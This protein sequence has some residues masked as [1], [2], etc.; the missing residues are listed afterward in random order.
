M[1][2]PTL[3]EQ[4]LNAPDKL[5]NKTFGYGGFL[6]KVFRNILAV[7]N[8]SNEQ[9]NG[10]LQRYVNAQP[11][12]EGKPTHY[13][14]GI[15]GNLAKAILQPHISWKTF[16]RGLQILRVVKFKMKI[17]LTYVNGQ[18]TT[19]EKEMILSENIGL[20]NKEEE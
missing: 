9:M 8:V 14:V 11:E 2:K 12:V 17:E 7:N 3:Q 10:M 16:C 18:T 5:E 4:I 13:K 19:H 1:K 6:A 15:K 20:A